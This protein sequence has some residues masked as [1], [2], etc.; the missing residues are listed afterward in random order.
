MRLALIIHDE[1]GALEVASVGC[2]DIVEGCGRMGWC[3]GRALQIFRAGLPATTATL[4]A[5][6]SQVES[7]VFTF[8]RMGDSRD[9]PPTV[10]C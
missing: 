7:L 4:G 2:E 3:V 9:I 5:E 8:E 10:S 1:S 6:S